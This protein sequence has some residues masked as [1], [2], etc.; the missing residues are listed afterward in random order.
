MPAYG[1]HHDDYWDLYPSGMEGMRAVVEAQRL[2]VTIHVLG[3][4]ASEDAPTA[5]VLKMPPNYEL[6]RHAHD[7]ERLEVVLEGSLSSGDRMLGPGDILKS[8]YRQQY[9]P[10][11]AGPDGCTT[12]EFF[13]TR[14]GAH[15]MLLE[16]PDG[17]RTVDLTAQEALV[18]VESN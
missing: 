13:S 3:D 16:E 6:L 2:R 8:G 18:A 1:I 5:I 7:C 14:A 11:Y 4:P 17:I 9:G 15:A 10:H 12:M